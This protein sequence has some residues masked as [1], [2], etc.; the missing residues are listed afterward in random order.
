MPDNPDDV[1]AA[2]AEAEAREIAAIDFVPIDNIDMI[3]DFS[4]PIWS[5]M[6]AALGVRSPARRPDH[7]P[8][9]ARSGF[10]RSRSSGD[11]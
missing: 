2:N 6:I 4:E 3:R 5:E 7:S 1:D 11:E 10:A 8:N 9:K